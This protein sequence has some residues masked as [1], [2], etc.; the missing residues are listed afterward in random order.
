[1]PATMLILLDLPLRRSSICHD[2]QCIPTH[3]L[4]TNVGHHQRYFS[5]ILITPICLKYRPTCPSCSPCIRHFGC[6]HWQVGHAIWHYWIFL[7]QPAYTEKCH[8]PC[9][10]KTHT[11]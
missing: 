8:R 4:N 10:A 9:A 2:S 1:M 7:K 3:T 5:L 6:A 11:N